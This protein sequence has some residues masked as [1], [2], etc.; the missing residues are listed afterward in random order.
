MT[1]IFSSLTGAV[2]PK[3]DAMLKA[4]PESYAS[5]VTVADA[6][7]AKKKRIVTVVQ[8]PGSGSYNTLDDS[9][10]RVNVRADDEY[11]AEDLT[12]LVRA[13]FEGPLVDGDPITYST[14]NAGPVPVPNDTDLFQWYFVVDV[15]RRGR[16]LV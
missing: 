2:I 16:E 15:G 12:L 5:G 6:V 13:L 14:V 4:R 3:L 7:V 11:D 1:V 8:G 10:L 9:M